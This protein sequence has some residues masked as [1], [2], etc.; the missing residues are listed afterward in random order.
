MSIRIAN[1]CVN[2]ENF[3]AKLCTK[4]HIN[5][6]KSYTCDS[7]SVQSSLIQGI[8]CRSCLRYQKSDCP[9]PTKAASGLSCG[10][11]APLNI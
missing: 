4:H 9:H 8:E 5:V 1:S 7:F 2:C 11:W 6:S 3:K 10:Q